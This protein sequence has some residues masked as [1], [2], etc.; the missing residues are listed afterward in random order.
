MA[1]TPCS[2]HYLLIAYSFTRK[3]FQYAVLFLDDGCKY[4]RA[5]FPTSNRARRYNHIFFNLFPSYF[6]S[7]TLG[8]LASG[9]PQEL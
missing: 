7:T 9:L 4:V 8:T 6:L 2:F 5:N 1:D 3:K